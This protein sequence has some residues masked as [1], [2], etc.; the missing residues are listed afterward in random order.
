MEHLVWCHI[1]SNQLYFNQT[2]KWNERGSC[3]SP[4]VLHYLQ[5]V[6]KCCLMQCRHLRSNRNLR[7]LD[8]DTSIPLVESNS[9]VR[10][11]G[12]HHSLNECLRGRQ[13]IKMKT[14]QVE[15]NKLSSLSL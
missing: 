14:E 11:M 13:D 7:P 2:F 15:L 1:L 4:S 12:G 3:L 10:W 6:A 8:L 5:T 9:A